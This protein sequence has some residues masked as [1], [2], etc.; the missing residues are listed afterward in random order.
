MK[1]LSLNF[2]SQLRELANVPQL[3]FQF[4]AALHCQALILQVNKVFL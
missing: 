1:L 2:L 4:Q 3:T